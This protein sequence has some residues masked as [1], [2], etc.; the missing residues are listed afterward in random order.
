MLLRTLALTELALILTGATGPTWEH[1]LRVRGNCDGGGPRQ[2]GSLVVAGNGVLSL[3]DPAGNV[4]PFARGPQGYAGEGGG[5]ESYMTV[6]PGHEVTGAGCS[7]AP[8][9]VFVL[10]LHAPVGITRVDAQGH[11][12][13]FATVTGVDSLGGI[14]FD[15]TGSFGYRLLVSGPPNGNNVIAAIDCKG[16]AQF[17][18]RTGPPLE[19]RPAVAPSGFG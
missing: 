4:S 7:F 1:W 5:A 18:P 14:A 9:D 2:D 12:S 16:A 6:S 19:G 11:A 17:L 13:P 3:G 10:R 15:T 8:D